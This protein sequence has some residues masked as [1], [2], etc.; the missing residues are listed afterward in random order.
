NSWR[1]P[2]YYTRNAF[3]LIWKNYPLDLVVKYTLAM[4]NYCIYYSLEQHTLIYLKAMYA[5]LAGIKNL[6]GKRKPV[7]REIAEN[8]RI[9]FN[10]SFTFYR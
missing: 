8:L 6:K 9:P 7:A 2:Y 3:W 10:V 5:A 4:I 1:A